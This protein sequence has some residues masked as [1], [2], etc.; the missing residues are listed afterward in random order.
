MV[1]DFQ[2]SRVKIN[3][4]Q[5]SIFYRLMIQIYLLLKRIVVTISEIWILQ[6]W[7]QNVKFLGETSLEWFGGEVNSKKTNLFCQ[8][9]EFY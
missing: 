4:K 6:G 7:I 9:C 8:S 3:L 2:T 5:F 1:N